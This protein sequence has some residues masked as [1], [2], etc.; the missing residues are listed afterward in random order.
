MYI[1]IYVYIYICIY[2][3]VLG[4]LEKRRSK[5]RDIQQKFQAKLNE[6]RAEIEHGY[7]QKPVCPKCKEQ[8]KTLFAKKDERG[9]II[10]AVVGNPREDDVGGEGGDGGD[11]GEGGGRAAKGSGGSRGGGG[12][13]TKSLKGGM[14]PSVRS[15]K[16]GKLTAF[17]AGW[18]ANVGELEV[19]TEEFNSCFS[20]LEIRKHS[21]IDTTEEH[22]NRKRW[23]TEGADG[24]LKEDEEPT[25]HHVTAQP[26]KDRHTPGNGHNARTL[27][28]GGSLS[29]PLDVPTSRRC[30]GRYFKHA[31]LTED[32]DLPCDYFCDVRFDIKPP[33]ALTVPQQHICAMNGKVYCASCMYDDVT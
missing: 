18:K 31:P 14:A 30:A 7:F 1:Y 15:K 27:A 32:E 10:D 12:S 16:Q 3:S 9:S 17:R 11:G 23:S 25:R 5:E 26:G 4:I 13:D 20:F 24:A 33:G 22:E 28:R 6:I 2:I 29:E 21:A 19:L 8:C